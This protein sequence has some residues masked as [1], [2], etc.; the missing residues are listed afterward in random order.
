MRTH[1]GRREDARKYVGGPSLKPWSFGPIWTVL[2]TAFVLFFT[3]ITTF[4]I[5]AAPSLKV[6]LLSKLLIMVLAV[7][8]VTAAVSTLMWSRYWRQVQWDVSFWAFVSGPPPEY[9]EAL[10]AWRWGRRFRLSWIVIMLCVFGVPVVE[11]IA[12]RWK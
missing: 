1:E 2:L 10:L 7:A 12:K 5:G 6:T 4:M 8:G 9:D 11:E 3:V